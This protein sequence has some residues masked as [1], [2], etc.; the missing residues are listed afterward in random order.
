MS[1]QV[2]DSKVCVLWLWLDVRLDD[3]VV[4]G[5]DHEGENYHNRHSSS[6]TQV[7]QSEDASKNHEG[8]IGLNDVLIDLFPSHC[9]TNLVLR[10]WGDHSSPCVK[11][12]RVELSSLAEHL[13]SSEDNNEGK[14]DTC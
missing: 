7:N 9:V 14:E 5:E 2:I 3:W 12:W 8:T 6:F 11:E 1:C 4:L 10:V 13:E